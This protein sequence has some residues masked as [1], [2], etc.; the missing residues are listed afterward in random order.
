M[1]IFA[2]GFGSGVWSEPENGEN[3]AP[4]TRKTETAPA[5]PANRRLAERNFIT[6]QNGPRTIPQGEVSAG[7]SSSPIAMPRKHG[8]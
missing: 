7:Y 1:V 4:Q 3:A 2:G 8:C 5:I 6:L